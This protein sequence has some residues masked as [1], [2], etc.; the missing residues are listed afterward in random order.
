MHV[1]KLLCCS[2]L[3]HLHVHVFVP[4]IREQLVNLDHTAININETVLSGEYLL[5]KLRYILLMS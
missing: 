5:S 2:A 4:I 3:Y 1:N